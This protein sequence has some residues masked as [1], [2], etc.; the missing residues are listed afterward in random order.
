MCCMKVV[1]KCEC[2]FVLEHQ[3]LL[4]NKE[5]ETMRGS[6][7]LRFYWLMK[8]KFKAKIMKLMFKAEKGERTMMDA[9]HFLLGDVGV[10]P[11]I[12][13]TKIVSHHPGK[14]WS[15]GEPPNL[16]TWK[17]TLRYN[18]PNPRN[19]VLRGQW[20]IPVNYGQSP[21]SSWSN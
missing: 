11:D 13:M 4:I 16:G 18:L 12:P 3:T 21:C 14:F 10:T 7:S 15:K 2:L 5:T 17:S 6:V 20:S 19:M 8:F 1:P 9:V